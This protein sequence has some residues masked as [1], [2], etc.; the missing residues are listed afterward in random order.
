M[1]HFTV[2]V[3]IPKENVIT[4]GIERYLETVLAP[5][6]ENM[7][8]EAYINVPAEELKAEYE[9]RKKENPEYEI[10]KMTLADY[11]NEWYGQDLD[12][13]GNLLSTYNP[14]S[15][16]DW[17]V[18]GGRW[19]NLLRLK[20]G[21]NV[22][23][24]FVEEIDFDGILE[25]DRQKRANSW[26]EAHKDGVPQGMQKFIYGIQTATLEEHVATA[27]G[28]TTFAVVTKDGEWCE[29]GSMGWWGVHSASSE[30]EKLW[31]ESYYKNF[32]EPLD[33]KDLIVI[34]DCHI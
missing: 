6:D 10:D 7:E 12:E 3:Q 19:R 32:I 14:N 31:E 8:A 33:P 11:A 34:V 5:F 16:W 13:E 9:K 23:F 30:E 17:W 15:K 20:N 1:S 24:A 25:E 27:S 26:A 4:G 28:L 21:D 29:K 22:D 2:M 18:I